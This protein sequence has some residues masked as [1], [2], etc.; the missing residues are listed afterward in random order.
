[1]GWEEK[2]RCVCVVGGGGGGLEE[3]RNTTPAHEQYR[4]EIA[5]V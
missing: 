3:R 1:M 4:P 2:G 5:R